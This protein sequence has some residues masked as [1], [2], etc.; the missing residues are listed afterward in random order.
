MLPSVRV[1]VARTVALVGSSTVVA[2]S[3]DGAA[4]GSRCRATP[5]YVTMGVV[6]KSNCCQFQPYCVPK[7]AAR[8]VNCQ[9][10]S[11]IHNTGRLPLSTSSRNANGTGSS[12][13]EPM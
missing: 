4:R 8:A 9:M 12:Y 11:F 7:S 1:A 3:P 6:A 5:L 2:S 13:V 10:L